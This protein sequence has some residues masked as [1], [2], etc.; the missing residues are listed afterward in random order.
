MKKLS[1]VLALI[2][3][4]AM[5]FGMAGCNDILNKDTTTTAA[6]PAAGTQKIA[7]GDIKIGVLYI[8]G[9]EETSGYTYAHHKGILE[10]IS[11]LGLNKDSQ[12]IIKDKIDDT[13]VTKTNAA[14]QE[15]IDAGCNIIFANSFNYMNSM[16]EFADN[17]KN[18]H[19]V[20]SHCSGFLSNP[21]N[22]NNYFGR[23][24][25]ARFL[26]GL[27][28]GKKAKQLFDADPANGKKL[29]YVAAMDSTNSE[30]TGGI[31]AFALG[32]QTVFPEAEIKVKVTGSWFDPTGEANAAKAL[33]QEGCNVI[34][35]HCDTDGPQVEAQNAKVFGCG[36]NS[37]MTAA[38]P[39]AHLTAPIWNWGVY[40]TATVEQVIN[41]S[42]KSVNYF[43]GMNKSLIGLSPINEK[44]AAPGTKEIVDEYQKKIEKGEFFVFAGPIVDNT[45][46]EIIKAGEKLTDAQITGEIN[47]YVKGVSLS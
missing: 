29:G 9:A 11:T 37:D 21:S 6:K 2:L 15:M 45:G 42:W 41:G 13:D 23:I 7:K 20:F 47:Y 17:P 27:A 35:Q 8:T 5:L 12:L 25:E 43:E 14:L 26:S 28:A 22:F 1:M 3:A 34:A 30:V 40:Y 39:D 33:I 36:Y 46:K 31:N 44:I 4:G 32:V 19:I 24:Y 16:K 10:M 38:A 18:A